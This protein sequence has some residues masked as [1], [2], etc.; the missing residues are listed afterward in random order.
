M[1]ILIQLNNQC[2]TNPT[3]PLPL[4]GMLGPNHNY[5][6]LLTGEGVTPSTPLLQ[7]C[8]FI[9]QHIIVSYMPHMPKRTIY[10]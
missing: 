7:S 5:Y 1:L 8:Y 3:T 10:T 9:L 2:G 4:L 6:R